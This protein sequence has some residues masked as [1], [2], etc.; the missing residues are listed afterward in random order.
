MWA[1]A[2]VNNAAFQPMFFPAWWQPEPDATVFQGSANVSYAPQKLSGEYHD[3]TTNVRQSTLELNDSNLK[4]EYPIED[5]KSVTQ[6]LDMLNGQLCDL[7]DGHG[8]CPP[9]SV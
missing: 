6:A 8:I 9:H 1:A 7:L 2:T 5:L 3:L 4:V